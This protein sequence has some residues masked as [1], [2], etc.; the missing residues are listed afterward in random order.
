[1]GEGVSQGLPARPPVFQELEGLVERARRGE[2]GV[3][4]RIRDI[5]NAHP[6]IWESLGDVGRHVEAAWVDLMVG[7]DPLG[8][9]VIQQRAASTRQELAGEHPTPIEK[10][11]VDLVVNTWLETQQASFSHARLA[12]QASS[13]IQQANYRLR[14]SE[15]AQK[16]LLAAL[17]SLATLRAL[18]PEGL[19]PLNGLRLL[20]EKEG[21]RPA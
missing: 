4:P 16:K 18:L 10:L 13:P 17:K 21:R 20:Q 12:G 1:M 2:A 3:L 19:A 5:L 9:E 14:R 6:G 7:K 11:M 8:R 15:V